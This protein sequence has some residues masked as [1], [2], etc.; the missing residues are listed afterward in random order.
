[1]PAIVEKQ[2]RW[3]MSRKYGATVNGRKQ[4][5]PRTSSEA[6]C[7][8]YSLLRPGKT[9]PNGFQERGTMVARSNGNGGKVS[10]GARVSEPAWSRSNNLRRSKKVERKYG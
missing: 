2:S 4:K 3:L 8:V 6:A 10:T 9:V 5:R 7:W 1:M